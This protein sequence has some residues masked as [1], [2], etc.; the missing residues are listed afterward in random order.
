M[1]GTC[2]RDNKKGGEVDTVREGVGCRVPCQRTVN[3]CRWLIYAGSGFLQVTVFLNAP[4][5]HPHSGKG[6]RAPA[7]PMSLAGL[8]SEQPRLGVGV[9]GFVTMPL[10]TYQCLGAA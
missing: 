5:E 2:G 8:Q 4:H 3:L 9:G 10:R 1:A 7:I 6:C